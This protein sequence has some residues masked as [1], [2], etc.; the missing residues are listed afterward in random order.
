MHVLWRKQAFKKIPRWFSDLQKQ[1]DVMSETFCWCAFF[2]SLK[3]KTSNFWRFIS[4]LVELWFKL[5]L[6]SGNHFTW[7]TFEKAKTVNIQKSASTTNVFQEILYFLILPHLLITYSIFI[8]KQPAWVSLKKQLTDAFLNRKRWSLCTFVLLL[9]LSLV[10]KPESRTCKFTKIWLG[11]S[12]KYLSGLFFGI[13][14]VIYI[15][16]RNL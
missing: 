2:Q 5:W 7:V 13:S 8:K 16:V 10:H 1:S 14:L 9:L 6:I 4:V 11:L 3:T 12:I 15:F